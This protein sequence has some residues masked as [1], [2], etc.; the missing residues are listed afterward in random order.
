[1]PLYL[2]EQ[3]I[4][5]IGINWNETI[6]AIEKT[7]ACL[8]EKDFAQ[9]IK[10]YLRFRDLKNRII[11]MPAFVGRG[12]EACGI[13][14]ISSFPSNTGHGKTRAYSVI[15]L[16]DINS[17]EPLSIQNTAVVS[18][19]RTASVSGL[20]MNY[21][22][23]SRPLPSI[24]LGIIGWGPIGRFHYK[25]SSEIL[26]DRISTYYLTDLRGIDPNTLDSQNRHNI[27]IVDSWK[28]IYANCDILIT[29]TVA[30]A[31][32]ITGKPIEGA[33]YLNVSLRDF[34]T[35]VYEYFKHSIV[36]DNWEEVCREKTDVEMMHLE[37]G[38]QK[39]DT[40]AIVDVIDGCINHFPSQHPVMFNPMGMAVFDIAI[41]N[42]YYLMAK[43]KGIGD[44]I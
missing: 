36:V 5:K 31:P 29:C 8:R 28:E 37:K 22:V 42:Y 44:K 12:I 10:P 27:K 17:G 9:P 19:I 7:V 20:V 14:W 21:Y 16:N 6:L 11:A 32:Y 24:K 43:M 13:K 4:F 18:A 30:D 3:H 39:R 15:I 33:L 34:K 35:D 23:K 2:N 26:G 41:A 25:M 40:K 1:M 38:L